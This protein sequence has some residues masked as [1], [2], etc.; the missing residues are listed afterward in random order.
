MAAT[1]AGGVTSAI[2]F[3]LL[4]GLLA[5]L[6]AGVRVAIFLAVAVLV[7]LAGHGLVRFGLPQTRQQIPRTVFDR[8]PG[9]AAARFGYELGTGLRTYLPSGAPHLLAAG[10]VVLGGPWWAALALGAGFGLG[11]GLLPSQRAIAPD[12]RRWDA[13]VDLAGPVLRGGGEAVALVGLLAAA[14]LLA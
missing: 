13:R 5:P 12:P 11:R 14:A 10:L 8:A 4:S 1:T 6:A 9:R 2:L 7:L 3:W